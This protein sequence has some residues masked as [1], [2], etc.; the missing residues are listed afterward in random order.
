MRKWQW[1]IKMNKKLE[2]III[3]VCA[4]MI[5]FSIIA[6]SS[7]ANEFDKQ[8]LNCT[9]NFG[10]EIVKGYCVYVKDGSSTSY[11]I[12]EDDANRSNS[13]VEEDDE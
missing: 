3:I 1:R 11:Y 13:A 4:A 2:I 10:G 12:W 9:K 6:F 5:I 8:S 7:R